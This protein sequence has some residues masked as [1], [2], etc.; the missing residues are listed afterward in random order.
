MA[1]IDWMPISKLDLFR[2]RIPDKTY[3]KRIGSNYQK[4]I[5]P[6]P[7]KFFKDFDF[8][9]AAKNY[10]KLDRNVLTNEQHILR[11]F[12]K[13]RSGFEYVDPENAVGLLKIIAEEGFFHSRYDCDSLK[14]I[15][16]LILQPLPYIVY[17]GKDRTVFSYERAKNIKKYG[18][19][20][21]F[22]KQ[23]IGVGGHINEGDAPKYI[24]K[25]LK[26]EANEE[27]HI[28]GTASEPRL[29]GTVVSRARKV[30]KNHFGLIYVVRVNGRVA[31]KKKEGSAVSG[32]MIPIDKLMKDK[33]AFR[34]YETWSKCLIPHLIELYNYSHT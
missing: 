24:K 7:A 13:T 12:R 14:F 17:F 5:G 23:S 10:A 2:T 27:V 28:F 25:N 33:E 31:V 11:S 3:G 15:D 20:G 19:R 32:E 8:D 26:R 21:L 34:N 18:E 9:W 22:G 16:P 30:D 4:Q 29:I 1:L 6:R